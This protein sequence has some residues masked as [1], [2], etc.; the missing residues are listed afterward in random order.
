MK[1]T[2]GLIYLDYWRFTVSYEDGDDANGEKNAKTSD[3]D[4]HKSQE[5]IPA[6]IL[7]V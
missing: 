4:G 2:I 6:H 3:T 5:G 7:Y 1:Q